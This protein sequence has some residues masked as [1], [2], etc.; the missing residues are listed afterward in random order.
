M[1]RKKTLQLVCL[2][3]GIVVAGTGF[4][5]ISTA[6]YYFTASPLRLGL[7]SDAQEVQ[8]EYRDMFPSD[9]TCHIKARVTPE[10]FAD[11]CREF[12]LTI[13]VPDRKYSDDI[14]WLSWRGPAPPPWF[15]PSE[16]ISETFDRQSRSEWTLAKYERGFLFVAAFSH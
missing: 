11:Y 7:P 3:V 13:H 4:W 6:W 5:G 1:T 15:D 8:Y 14:M 16:S 12:K 9:Y 2:F 10:Q